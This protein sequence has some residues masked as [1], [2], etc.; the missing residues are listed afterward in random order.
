M[1]VESCAPDVLSQ[2]RQRNVYSS[3]TKNHVKFQSTTSAELI[4][5]VSWSR[6]LVFICK[7][8]YEAWSKKIADERLAEE[9]QEKERLEKEIAEQEANQSHET[10]VTPPPNT[11]KGEAICHR[12]EFAIVRDEDEMNCRNCK[13]SAHFYC[14][15]KKQRDE[16]EQ[17]F[18]VCTE[19]DIEINSNRSKQSSDKNSAKAFTQEKKTEQGRPQREKNT[20]GQNGAQSFPPVQKFTRSSVK[21]TNVSHH[22]PKTVRQQIPPFATPPPFVSKRSS[23][24]EVSHQYMPHQH[25]NYVTPP[26]NVQQR[27]HEAPPPRVVQPSH[28]YAGAHQPPLQPDTTSTTYAAQPPQ[29]RVGYNSSSMYATPLRAQPNVFQ[30]QPTGYGRS[31]FNERLPS[32]FLTPPRQQDFYAVNP[33]MEAVSLLEIIKDKDLPS[34]TDKFSS[35]NVFY[36]AYIATRDNYADHSNVKRVGDAIKCQEIRKKIGHAINN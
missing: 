5:N 19:C 10:I 17:G 8:H 35:F 14:L 24:P 21:N 6:A 31:P 9:Q 18:F 26:F 25:S 33:R 29:S 13:N 36:E 11:N 28:S 34:V 20:T 4:R 2:D 1:T 16:A 23:R 27:H 30:Q 22:Y 12:C 7:D 3:A 15:K 32:P